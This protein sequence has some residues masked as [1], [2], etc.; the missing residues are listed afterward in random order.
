MYYIEIVRSRVQ[1][2]LRMKVS[3]GPFFQLLEQIKMAVGID[4]D[5]VLADTLKQINAWHNTTYNTGFQKED[6]TTWKHGDIW[7]NTEEEVIAKY[8]TFL[9]SDFSKEI[10]PFPGSLEGIELL[11]QKDDLIVVTGRSDYLR[12]ETEQW[13]GEHFP[14]KFSGINFTNT[15]IGNKKIYTP[16]SEICKRLGI[17]TL[18][19]D[20]PEYTEGC[21]QL[22]IRVLL[23]DYFWNQGFD[24]EGVER[25]Y[26]WFGNEEKPGVVDNVLGFC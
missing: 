23:F 14:G 2:S 21:V 22:G 6:Y 16:K 12:E 7:G 8:R 15:Y 11:A 5:N 20:C 3:A 25:V 24:P 4:L 1:I 13:I 9:L 19:D 26:G 18:I 17:H 10:L